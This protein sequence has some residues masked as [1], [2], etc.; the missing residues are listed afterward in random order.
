MMNLEFLEPAPP[1]LGQIPFAIGEIV[2]RNGLREARRRRRW[3]RLSPKRTHVARIG[4]ETIESNL[5]I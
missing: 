1:T 2:R 5:P 3:F 4:S